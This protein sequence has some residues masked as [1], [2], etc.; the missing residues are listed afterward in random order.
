MKLATLSDG[1]R[2]G[3]LVVV[4]RDQRHA[5]A[6]TAIAPSLLH[7]LE[8]WSEV[9]APLQVLSA[10]LETG[11]ASATFAF[12]ARQAMAPL[13]R[14]PQWCDGSAF[15]NHGRLMERA[16]NT[17]P[18]PLFDTVPVMYQG[19]SDDFLGAHHDVPLPD[20]AH[21]IDFEGEFGVITGEVPMGATPAEADRPVLSRIRDL[22]RR[23]TGVAS[24][25]PQ[26][27]SVTSRYASSSERG[28]TSGVT[29]RKI[30]KT[31]DEAAL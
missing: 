14:A 12:D 27:F 15:L 30:A 25:S 11:N 26:A 4:S 13:P 21:G 31:A 1:S 20:V 19:A 9:Q 2:D 3:R 29:S 8:H 16:F 18:I 10:A 28:S 7:A 24:G 6:A 22:S 23:A 5:V 17:P